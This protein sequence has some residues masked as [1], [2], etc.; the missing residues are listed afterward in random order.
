MRYVKKKVAKDQNCSVD[1]VFLLS[2]SEQKKKA[3]YHF[4]ANG[5]E[6]T[7]KRLGN[8]IIKASKLF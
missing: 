6:V 5:T 7:Y 1:D 8:S 4:C 3:V 2:F